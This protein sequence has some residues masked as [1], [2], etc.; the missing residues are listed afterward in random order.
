M[1]LSTRS[2]YGIH[3]MYE[4]ALR[5]GDA[6][7]SIKAIAERRGIPEAYLEQLI[8]SLRRDGLVLS[9]RGAQG[10]YTL[11]RPPEEISV[12][13][14]LRSMEDGPVL[15]DCLLEED[16]CGKTCDCPTRVLWKKLSDGIARIVDGISLK[17]KT[18]GNMPEGEEI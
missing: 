9:V 10:G 16:A 15:V 17:D 2:R 18:E 1:K 5:Y 3:A 7:V 14:I 4:L 11:S 8:A 13:D 12:G 6:P